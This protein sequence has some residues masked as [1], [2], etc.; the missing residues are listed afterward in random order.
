[1]VC[2]GWIIVLAAAAL[3]TA[4]AQDDVSW[5]LGQINNL[6]ASQGLPPFTL[7]AQL[8][9]AATQQSQYLAQTCNIVH[10]W[11]DGTTPQMRAAAQGYPGDH[12]IEN[13][14]AGTNATAADAWNF[15]LNSPVHYAGLTNTLDDEIGIGIA[16]GGECGHA[17]TLDFGRSGS[18]AAPAAPPANPGAAVA[19][20]PPTP[21][22]YVPPPPTR[23]PTATIPTLTPSATWT[24]TPSY[25]PSPTFTAVSPT[26]TPLE[27]PTVPAEV[28][29]A[30]VASPTLTAVPPTLTVTPVPPT[31]TLIP[32]TPVP[33]Q[34]AAA[35]V[36]GSGFEARDLIP[37][38][39][40][41]QIVLIGVAGFVYFR[42]AR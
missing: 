21:R 22:P 39:L 10:T 32:P 40:V 3:P 23:T 9:A 4:H 14:Y 38:A 42:K 29:V 20:A 26:A 5:L 12:V 28:A 27:L 25:T 13:I 30:A 36:S 8:S 2:L 37:F 31:T 33:V 19:A 6:R 11:P 1:M 18:G 15:W 41:G 16:H 7:N 34:Q 35:R 17:Y 24:L